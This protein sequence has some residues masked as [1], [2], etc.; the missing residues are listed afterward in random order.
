MQKNWNVWKKMFVILLH[1]LVNLI[2]ILKVLLMIQSWHK[3][4]TYYFD[5]ADGY[6]RKYD[7]TKYLALF[8]SD[9]KYERILIE[10]DTNESNVSDIYSH[11]FIKIKSNSDGDLY[12]YKSLYKH[13]VVSMLSLF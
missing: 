10:L 13:N 9:E 3:V 12:A 8:H 2:N 5:K 4:T 1:V 7:G 6:I 11:R